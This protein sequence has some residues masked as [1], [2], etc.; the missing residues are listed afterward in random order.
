MGYFEEHIEKI[1]DTPGGKL[2]QVFG[3]NENA[4]CSVALVKMFDNSKGVLHYHEK[5]TEI[6]CF[7]K[8]SGKIN[9]NGNEHEIISGDCYVITPTNS[10]LIQIENAAEFMC[11]CIPPWSEKLEFETNKFTK[12][13][14]ISKCSE[15][16]VIFD[17]DNVKIESYYI[18]KNQAKSYCYN[19]YKRTVVYFQKG[20][21]I[22]IIDE[23]A[24]IIHEAECF[25]IK[26]GQK[27][28][29]IAKKDLKYII[30]KEY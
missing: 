4:S 24:S 9:I 14:D 26:E 29:I 1:C 3:E 19:S 13:R 11:I 12:N 28:E 30:L 5:I 8:G 15:C 6:Y 7:S 16:G 10:H 23:N 2:C 18:V 27:F 20:N 21:G 22:I 25:E 17:S